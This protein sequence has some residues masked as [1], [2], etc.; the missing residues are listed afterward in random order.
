MMDDWNTYQDARADRAAVAVT[1]RCD[2][3]VNVQRPGCRSLW[4]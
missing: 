3:C 4:A 2:G 1:T